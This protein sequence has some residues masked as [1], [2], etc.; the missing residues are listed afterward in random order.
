M[1]SQ[2]ILVTGATGKTGSRIA[3]R[4]TA[5]GQDVRH[6]SRSAAL[7][8]DWTSAATWMPVLSG[9]AAVYICFQPDFAFPGALDTLSAFVE[10]AREAGA[11]RVVMITGRGEPHAERGEAIVRGSGIPATILRCA[12]FAQNFSEGSLR[13]AVRSG[14]LPMP[15][16]GIKE[17]IIDVEDIA[18]VAVAA[19]TQSGHADQ[20][21]ELTGPQLLSFADI[22]GMLSQASGRAVEYVPISFEQFH[23]ELERAA[24]TQFADIVTAIARETFDGR[25]AHLTGGVQRAIGRPPREFAAFAEQAARAGAWHAAA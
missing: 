24:D 11:R 10:T 5:L 18:D 6:G 17:P 23:S 4:L 12:W 15:G 13:D 14:I 20:I 3:S 25:N 9:V 19:L 7:P 8:F 21:Y 22:A 2:T 16:D 1:P